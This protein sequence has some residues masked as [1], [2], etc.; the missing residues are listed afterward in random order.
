MIG[1]GVVKVVEQYRF[2]LPYPSLPF[3]HHRKFTMHDL[4]LR[5]WGEE[6]SHTRELFS[7]I[8]KSDLLAGV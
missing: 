8:Q 7:L 4:A 1:G 3:K 6:I 5:Q 2:P